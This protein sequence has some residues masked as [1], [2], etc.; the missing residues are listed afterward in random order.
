MQ[1][2]NTAGYRDNLARASGR[3]FDYRAPL[4]DGSWNAWR[5]D[6]RAALRERLGLNR[7][8]T[9]PAGLNPRCTESV[10][11]DGY[12]R[13]KW[14]VTSEPGIEIPFY[15]LLPGT[16]EGPY[17]LIITPHGHG[18]RGKETYVANYVTEED[19]IS[20]EQGERDVAVQAVK[21]GYAVIAPD[22]RGFFEMGGE[23]EWLKS[24]GKGNS[25]VNF[26]K[27]A[28]MYGR[29]LIGERVH[30]MGRLIDYAATRPEIDTSR[31]VMTGNSGGGTVTLF[32]AALDDRISVAV[33]GSY[34]CTFEKSIIP[35]GHCPCNIVPGIL[36]LGE[37]YDVAALIAP[38]PLLIVHGVHD[39]IYPIEGT[40]ETY[41]HLRNVYA[42]MDAESSCELYEGSGGHRY[43][44]ERVWPFVHTHLRR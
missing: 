3:T 36:E 9:V 10:E 21:E 30:D 44:K 6:F 2:F 20:S 5:A 40:R 38:R 4:S 24:D 7:I 1:Y 37:M 8:G 33:P 23:E 27:V 18:A 31:I 13:E 39:E 42:A 11:C 25:C 41:G 22:V 12:T 14:Y 28:L 32:T 15:L 26:Q 43:Y 19:R 35:I 16:G 34:V 29:T 17:P